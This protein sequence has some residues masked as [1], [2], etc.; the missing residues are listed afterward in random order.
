MSV[1]VITGELVVGELA[2]AQTPETI[3]VHQVETANLLK[4]VVIERGLSVN[5]QGKAHIV[6]EGW[7]LLGAFN[8]VSAVVVETV[9]LPDGAGWKATVEARRASDG[10]VLGRADAICT[11]SERQWAKRDEYALLSMAQ[12]RATSKSLKQCLGHIVNLAGFQT[13]PAEEMP[14]DLHSAGVT[15]VQAGSPARV[16]GAVT[17]ATVV[18]VIGKGDMTA[19]NGLSAEAGLTDTELAGLMCKAT[20]HPA[21][22]SIV[23]EHSATVWVDAALPRFP[24]ASVPKLI[25]LI[26]RTDQASV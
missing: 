1:D 3:L 19:V 20:G 4:R 8:G 13:T 25:E 17:P 15:T 2:E 14:H 6:V 5:V 16:E 24:A 18:P 10:A 26:K 22:D 21:P 23:G 9:A 7:Q 12:T 11:R